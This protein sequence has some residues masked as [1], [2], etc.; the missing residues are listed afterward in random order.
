MA[1]FL[2]SPADRWRAGREAGEGAQ[3]RADG[4]R[5]QGVVAVARRDAPLRHPTGWRAS[6]R[7]PDLQGGLAP[8][9]RRLPGHASSGLGG[10]R[11]LTVAGAVPDFHRL[12]E[13]L[14]RREV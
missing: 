8:R 5:A 2:R 13:H 1:C 10:L 4:V 9:A 14:E 12:P 3:A 11:L 6:G 7:S